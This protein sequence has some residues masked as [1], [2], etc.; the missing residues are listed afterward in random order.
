M[1]YDEEYWEHFA[2]NFICDE[3]YKSR[4]DVS[5]CDDTTE[6]DKKLIASVIESYGEIVETVINKQIN[7]F[8]KNN[9]DWIEVRDELDALKKELGL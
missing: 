7:N 3:C 2:D 6:H 4:D 8:V 5:G 9:T 1:I